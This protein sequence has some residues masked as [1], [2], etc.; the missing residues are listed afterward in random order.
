MHLAAKRLFSIAILTLFAVSC[1]AAPAPTPSPPPKAGTTAAPTKAPEPAK[2]AA[3]PT[4]APAKPTAAPKAVAPKPKTLSK[5]KVAYTSVSGNYVP[6]WIA[7]E[8]KLFEKYGLDV[9]LTFIS[10]STTALNALVSGEVPIVH[11]SAVPMISAAVGGTDVQIVASLFNTVIM[12]LMVTP[13]INGPQDLKGKALGVSRLGS[14]TDIAL[15]YA[16]RKL[17]LDPDKDV[18]IMQVG[19][20]AEILAGMKT[21]GIAGGT[22][23]S[24]TDLMARAE[25]F[26]ELVDVAQ[27]GIQYPGTTIGTTRR[28]IQ[29]NGPVVENFLR[30]IIEGTYMYKANRELSMKIIGQYT[31]TDDPKIQEATW[32]SYSA[33][34]EKI[35]YPTREAM[36]VGIDEV[37]ASNEKAKGKS[38]DDFMDLQFVKKLESS[39][40]IK[41]IHKE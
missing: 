35:P 15:R 23:S 14:L 27:A 18:T 2:T 21:G 6:V 38:P 31:K 17:G 41:Q 28:F 26:K 33:K 4:A 19:G 5:V 39:G 1:A 40:F 9:D 22:L 37:A 7:K 25:G 11:G 24:P 13:D 30:A 8:E 36:Q 34:V 3:A 29:S 12:Y 32:K 10:S 16:L 20:V